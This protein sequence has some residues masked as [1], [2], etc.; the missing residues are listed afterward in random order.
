MLLSRAKRSLSH[1]LGSGALRADAA[2]GTA[3][4]YLAVVVI[5]GMLALRFSHLWWVDAVASLFIVGFL[6]RE[7][8]EAWQSR[9]CC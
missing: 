2:Q 9:H 4:W 1:D 8:R 7:A 5:I 3:C 6:A